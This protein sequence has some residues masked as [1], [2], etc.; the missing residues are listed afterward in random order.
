[1]PGY[2]E[3]GHVAGSHRRQPAVGTYQQLFGKT[4]DVLVAITA[5]APLRAK[6]YIEAVIDYLLRKDEKF[7]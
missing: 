5:T 1:M 7:P 2:I 6:K 4:V 3:H